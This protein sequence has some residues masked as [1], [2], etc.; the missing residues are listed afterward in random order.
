[1]PRDALR[2]RYVDMAP[3]QPGAALLKVYEHG[4][5][6]VVYDDEVGVE[7]NPG[8]VRA[9]HRAVGLPHLAGDGR[10]PALQRVVD[11]L[12]DLEESAVSLHHLPPDVE[13]DV[14]EEGGHAHKEL[15]DP[16][17]GGGGIDVKPLLPGER[18]GHR[19]LTP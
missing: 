17:A 11:V 7:V 13:A 6:G 12:R 14:L 2:R 18:P 10:A 4:G 8:G 15:G 9:V 1:M 3:P 19:P 16:A 5:L